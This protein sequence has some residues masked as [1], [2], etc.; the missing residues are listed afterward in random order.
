MRYNLLVKTRLVIVAVF[1]AST[2]AF[3]QVG[4]GR[5]NPIGTLQV[6]TAGTYEGVIP[7]RLTYAQLAAKT[8]YGA[9]QAG[10]MVYVTDNNTAVTTGAVQFVTRSGP[11]YFD[12]AKWYPLAGPKVYLGTCN[13]GDRAAG[14]GTLASTGFI[15]SAVKTLNVYN[16]VVTITHNLNLTGNQY[17][18]VSL[19]SNVVNTVTWY[20][21]DNDLT[22]PVITDVT[23]NSFK[24]NVSEF[25]AVVQAVSFHIQLVEY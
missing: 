9:S 16:D 22:E 14:Y 6:A 10:A 25:F 24:I 13:F 1:F 2:G 15:V 20:N 4:V 23:A 21:N 8:A 7:P 11:Y 19:V 12:G 3:A 17:V 5:S 18:K